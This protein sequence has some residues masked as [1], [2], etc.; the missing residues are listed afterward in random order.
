MPGRPSTCDAQ[1]DRGSRLR[2]HS[3][4]LSFAKVL[5]SPWQLTSNLSK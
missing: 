5:F 3:R 1:S 4:D 2:S